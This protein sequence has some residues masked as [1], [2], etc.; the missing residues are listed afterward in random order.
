MAM[1]R[2]I[3]CE[4]WGGLFGGKLSPDGFCRRC[5][6]EHQPVIATHERRLLKT[7]KAAQ[8]AKRHETKLSNIADAIE[9]T[10]ILLKYEGYGIAVIQPPASTFQHQLRDAQSTAVNEMIRDL[11][12]EADQKA[13]DAKTAA[14]KVG[15]YNKAIERLHKIFDYAEDLTGVQTTIAELRNKRDQLHYQ[16][17]KNKAAAAL[18][19]GN[20][21]AALSC[22]VD[23]FIALKS[24]STPDEQQRN[25]LS[26]V[27]GKIKE[28]GGTVPDV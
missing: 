22:Y 27:E 5:Y 12:F 18:A 2:C 17:F 6:D 8:S 23:A 4:K 25:I 19:K 24:D 28:L 16:Q 11:R 13:A 15:A 20:Q 14:G 21:K 1:A 9:S 3:I 26:E 10:D 7:F